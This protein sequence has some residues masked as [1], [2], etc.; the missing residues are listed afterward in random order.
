VENDFPKLQISNTPSQ[1]GRRSP[2]LDFFCH[3]EVVFMS[4]VDVSSPH[5]HSIQKYACDKHFESIHSLTG[6]GIHLG[7]INA[8]IAPCKTNLGLGINCNPI[9]GFRL[10]VT[11]LIPKL[12]NYA[13]TR[14][15]WLTQTTKA[16]LMSTSALDLTINIFFNTDC[17]STIGNT[18]APKGYP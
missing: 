3:R 11:F 17:I 6:E 16:K 15:V 1:R 5:M 7:H 4:H 9:F 14:R 8:G 18:R 10:V 2:Y 13:G 12:P